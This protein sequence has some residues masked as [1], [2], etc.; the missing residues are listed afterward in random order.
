MNL[1]CGRKSDLHFHQSL[2]EAWMR[3]ELVEKWSREYPFLFD[4]D[5]RR[6]A[7]SQCKVGYHFGEWFTAIA[8]FHRY[9]LHAIVGK[10]TFV[11]HRWKTE[12]FEHVVKDQTLREFLR[13]T[14]DTKRLKRPDLLV[15]RRDLSGYCF[16]E[17]KVRDRLTQEQW[18][19]FQE[20]E[21]RTG[22]PWGLMRLQ[23]C[24]AQ[25]CAESCFAC[26]GPPN[27]EKQ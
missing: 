18:T 4:L 26:A 20:I 13:G 16:I 10:Y 12:A 23:S 24:N 11:G 19:H 3:G 21:R 1:P 2:R 7:R 9:E 22:V 5:N 25:D 14:L 15:Y 6:N 27:R 17:V 8:L